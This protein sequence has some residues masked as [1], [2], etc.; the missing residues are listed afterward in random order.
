VNAASAADRHRRPTRLAAMKMAIA[1]ATA[2]AP[3]WS[4]R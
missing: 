3:V 1:A 4:K 2:Q